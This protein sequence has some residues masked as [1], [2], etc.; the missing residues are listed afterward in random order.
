[1][2]KR[3]YL[4]NTAHT[5]TPTPDGAWE[6]TS[7][8]VRRMLEE[9]KLEAAAPAN[10]AITTTLNVPAGAVDVL[11]NQHISAP[12]S[13]NQTIAGAIKGQMRAL[14]SNAAADL[15]AQCVIW[16]M[17]PDGTS[18]GT[19]VA[20]SASALASEFATGTAANREFP[21]GS[22]VTPSS[23][24]ALD[25]D[26][27]VVETGYR[28]HENATTSRTGTVVIGSTAGGTDLPEDE[29][30]TTNNVP[31]IEFADTLVFQAT[32]VRVSQLG[33][34]AAY[35]G[36]PEARVSQLGVEVVYLAGVSASAERSWGTI[37]S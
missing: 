33:V 2:A 4:S 10:S 15:R 17:K 16:V 22:P 29:S 3:L 9:T 19:L 27:I 6:V 37:I 12:L 30:T 7:G 31:W 35:I 18:R 26:R 5:L 11:I 8:F 23:V 21:L 1:M 36:D 13:G 24:A 25:G 20:A 28:K 34:E 14:E 32:Q